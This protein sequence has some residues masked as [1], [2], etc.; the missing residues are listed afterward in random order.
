MK[1]KWDLSTKEN[2]TAKTTVPVSLFCIIEAKINALG[3]LLVPIY[4]DTQKNLK[5]EVWSRDT[6]KK[7]RLRL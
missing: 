5:L 6:T 2:G 4:R 7:S 3:L 1:K